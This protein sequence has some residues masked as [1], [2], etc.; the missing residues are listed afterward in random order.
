MSKET[1]VSCCRALALLLEAWLVE[2]LLSDVAV[3]SLEPDVCPRQA[4]NVLQHLYFTTFRYK[5]L[6]KTIA[7]SV[8]D[9]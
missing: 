2:T 4:G 1:R 7:T 8:A 5:A 6:N 3:G 9:P